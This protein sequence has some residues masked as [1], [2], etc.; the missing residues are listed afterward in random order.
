MRY[1]MMSD[2]SL[3]A[4]LRST[5]ISNCEVVIPNHI[6]RHKYRG[7]TTGRNGLISWDVDILIIT[8]SE[9]RKKA[10]IYYMGNDLHWYVCK[11]CRNQHVLSDALRTGC[12]K[13]VWPEIDTV[14]CMSSCVVSTYMRAAHLASLA[15]LMVKDESEYDPKL[16]QRAIELG[17]DEVTGEE[18][19]QIIEDYDSFKKRRR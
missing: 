2:E 4:I 19:L 6:Y 11:Y 13:K 12:I 10:I 18:Y 8:D 1:D 3:C 16:R 5:K 9:L 7:R 14:T 15:G 17:L